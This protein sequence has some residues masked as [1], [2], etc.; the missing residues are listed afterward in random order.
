MRSMILESYDTKFICRVNGDLEIW[1]PHLAVPSNTLT[2]GDPESPSQAL[3]NGRNCDKKAETVTKRPRLWQKGRGCD[4][5]AEA[6]TK[7]PRLWQKAETVTKTPKLW[8][9]GR[10]CEKRT[11]LQKAGLEIRFQKLNFVNFDQSLM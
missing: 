8:Q 1:I 3:S 7:R 2:T 9:K 10:N 11:D 4:K 6:V 5:K